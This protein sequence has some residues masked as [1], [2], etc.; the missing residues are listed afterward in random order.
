MNKYKIDELIIKIYRFFAIKTKKPIITAT[1]KK[2]K[3]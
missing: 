2:R 1:Q 3:K